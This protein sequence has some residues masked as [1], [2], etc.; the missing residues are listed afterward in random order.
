MYP[1]HRWL[2]SANGVPN[3]PLRYSMWVAFEHLPQDVTVPLSMLTEWPNANLQSTLTAADCDAENP[4]VD[5]GAADKSAGV[6]KYYPT[7][8]AAVVVASFIVAIA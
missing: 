3:D 4:T 8:I 2:I 5:A 1:Y 6:L 7:T